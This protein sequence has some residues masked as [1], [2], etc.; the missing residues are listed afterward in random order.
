MVHSPAVFSSDAVY[1]D[2][3]GYGAERRATSK[4]DFGI[5]FDSFRY[6]SIHRKP[7]SWVTCRIA[8]SMKTLQS[9]HVRANMPLNALKSNATQSEESLSSRRDICSRRRTQG[10]RSLWDRGDSLLLCPP[11]NPARST[12]L[13]ELMMVTRVVSSQR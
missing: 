4:A 11:N 7:I 6:L 2:D 5:A 3:G 12:P 8:D 13:A 1:K 10:R 9:V